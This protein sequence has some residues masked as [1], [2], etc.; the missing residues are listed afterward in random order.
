MLKKFTEYFFG[1][2]GLVIL[3]GFIVPPLVSAKQTELV[4]VGISLLLGTLYGIV[5]FFI[6]QK[7]KKK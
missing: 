5:V 2:V 7:E 6:K 3:L 1:V 4:V